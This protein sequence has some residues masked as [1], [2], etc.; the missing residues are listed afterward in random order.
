MNDIKKT[1][2]IWYLKNKDRLLKKGRLY[3]RR[4]KGIEPMEIKPKKII[5]TFD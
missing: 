4:K 2:A 5:L 1:K 3:Y